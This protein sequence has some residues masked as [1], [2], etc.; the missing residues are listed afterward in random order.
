MEGSDRHNLLLRF[1]QIVLV[2]TTLLYAG[3]NTT[4]G[5]SLLRW[6]RTSG[7]FWAAWWGNGSLLSHCSK[8]SASG[9]FHKAN[10]EN[11]RRIHLIYGN[12][13]LYAVT[14]DR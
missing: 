12:G 9:P 7:P 11:R 3:T 2:M 14:G 4:S 13:K 8:K 10:R 6:Q 5:K 1:W